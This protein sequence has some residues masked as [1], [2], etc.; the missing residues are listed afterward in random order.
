MRLFFI[1]AFAFFLSSLAEAQPLTEIPIPYML[2]AA[3]EAEIARDLLTAIEWYEKVY[4]ETRDLSLAYKIATLHRDLRDYLKAER[5]FGRV[6]A[7]DKQTQFPQALFYQGWMNQYLEDHKK[8]VELVGTFLK[9][10]PEAEER[11]RAMWVLRSIKETWEMPDYGNVKVESIGTNIN[12]PLGESSPFLDADGNLYYTSF[13]EEEPIPYNEEEGIEKF[14]LLYKA[15]PVSAPEGRRAPKKG[16][17]GD[18][19]KG[20]S[21][22]NNVNREGY[23]IGSAALSKDEKVLYFTRV[24]LLGNV[25][26]NSKI[27]YSIFDK[28][29]WGPAAEVEGINGDFFSKHP[30]MGELFGE[31]VIFFSSDMPGGEGGFDLYYAPYLEDGKF[32][33]PVNLGPVLNTPFDEVTPYYAEGVLHFSSD[34]WP[35]LGGFDVF[36]SLWDGTRWSDPENMGRGF[37]SSADDLFFYYSEQGYKGFVVSNRAEGNRSAQGKTCCDDILVFEREKTR[38]DLLASFIYRGKPLKGGVVEIYVLERGEQNLFKTITSPDSAQYAIP[39]ELDKEY[40]IVAYRNDFSRDSAFISTLDLKRSQTFKKD[41]NLRYTK[42]RSDVEIVKINEPIRLSNIYYDYD[43]DKILADAEEDLYYLLELMETHPEMVIEL[44]SHTDARGK[45]EYNLALSQ[46]R[47]NSAKDWMVNKGIL[48][49]RIV[50]MG[51]GEQQILNHCVNDVNCS[52]EEHR[53]NRRTEFKILKGPTTLEIE[54]EV[55]RGRK[56][57]SRK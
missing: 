50:P 36:Y 27:Y 48:E 55:I 13:N 22:N 31:Q 8:A 6:V 46:R 45:D 19:E 28:G 10:Y 54:K 32:G 3:E 38:A 52:E 9:E 49:D 40:K 30:E 57:P 39:L 47:A 20:E 12:T 29:D 56:G 35:S 11:D 43:D 53:L 1:C 26:L 24:E 14:F 42:K 4:E 23:H 51:Y 16:R 44:S 2:E 15:A 25:V 7:R 5:W 33:L 21:V 34:G 41:F 17:G 37:N 18:W